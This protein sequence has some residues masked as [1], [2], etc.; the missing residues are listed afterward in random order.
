[1]TDG[2]A[3]NAQLFLSRIRDHYVQQLLLFVAEQRRNSIRGE[4]EVKLELEPGS[5]VFRSLS[6]ADFVRN[7][8]EPEIVEFEP[9]RILG[10]EPVSTALGDAGL[11]I[12]SLR[13]DDVVVHHNG[14]FDAEQVLGAWF[15]KWFDPDDRRYRHGA[16][17][18]NV[19]HS[20]VVEPARL[21]IDFGSAAP[22]SFWE[23]LDR[24]ERA[25]ATELRITSSQVDAGNA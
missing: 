18:G 8:A 3:S 11:E 10:F 9:D 23:L 22:E 15:E 25:G 7:D 12:E 13:W 5:K 1:V 6:C 16:D 21:T 2:T 19:I 24:L 4:A 20:L 17:L 14:A